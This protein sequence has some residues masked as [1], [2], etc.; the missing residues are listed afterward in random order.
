MPLIIAA[1]GTIKLTATPITKVS[2]SVSTEVVTGDGEIIAQFF[3][4]AAEEVGDATV[5]S[6]GR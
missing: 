6:P 1:I 2:S 5:C 4:A 3:T